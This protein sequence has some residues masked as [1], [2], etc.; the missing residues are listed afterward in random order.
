[1]MIIRPVR[2]GDVDAIVAL[3]HEAG[4]GMSNLPADRDE[5]ATRIRI[6]QESLDRS[7][8]EPSEEFYLFVLEDGESGRI[9]GTAG[10]MCG[11]GQSR[12]FYSYKIIKRVHTSRA[13]GR[14]DT[15]RLL[16]IV[17]EYQG[18]TEV[19]ALY[20]TASQ[21]GEGRG[22]LLARSRYL[23]LAEHPER[24]TDPVMAEMRGVIDDAGHS[25]FWDSL[26]RCFLHMD[27]SR[28]DY[29]HYRGNFQIIVDLLPEY[30]VYTRLLPENAQAVIGLTHPETVPALE[31]LKREGFRFEGCINVFDGGPQLH[32][33]RDLIRSLRES[34]SGAIT[35]IVDRCDAL[36]HLISNTRLSEFR[37][38]QR[39][40]A[41]IGE[42]RLEIDGATAAALE[43][44]VGDRIRFVPA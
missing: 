42:D 33:P 39:P 27:F 24:F 41:R 18:V 19:G 5:L 38:C 17:N 4:H 10:I 9:A 2:T 1:M 36:P 30:P 44:E 29:L 28:A 21:R 12:P 35:R 32:V 15:V 40:L 43:I 25:V 13:I 6:C 34:E 11:I 22:K 8:E 14:S 23:F 26:G 3:A 31:L 16:Q 37:V 20:L 7:I